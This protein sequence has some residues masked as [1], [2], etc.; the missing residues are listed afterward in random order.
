LFSIPET[1]REKILDFESRHPAPV[2]VT[3]YG[4]LIPETENKNKE[5]QSTD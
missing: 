2:L 3:G 1:S 5:N 4:E